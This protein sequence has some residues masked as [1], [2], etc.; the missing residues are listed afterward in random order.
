[1]E[2]AFKA[3]KKD[4]TC[5]MGKGVFQYQE[6]VW[7]EEDEANVSENGLHACL[8][9]LDCFGYYSFSPENVVYLA[10]AD[11]DISEDGYGTRISCTRLKLIRSLTTEEIVLHAM[12]YIN[13]HPELDNS[14]R[15]VK[16]ERGEADNAFII[17]RGKNP[18][19]QG[20][21]GA[22]LGL[23]KEELNSRNII[24]ASIFTVDGD[25]V[26]EDTYYRMDGTKAGG[27]L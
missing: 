12:N 8:N 23:L 6:G 1:M 3:L 19:A 22:V 10:I 20:K 14:I 4:L 24:G 7:I 2:I 11:G 27:I 5:T 13:L 17:V 15:Y 16:E 25:T 9:V 21:K 18:A 26:E